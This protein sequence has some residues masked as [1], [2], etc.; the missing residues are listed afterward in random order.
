MYPATKEPTPMVATN[1]PT[2]IK[3]SISETPP[4][5][6]SPMPTKKRITPFLL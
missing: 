3:M 6:D 1:T 5:R 2:P 4:N